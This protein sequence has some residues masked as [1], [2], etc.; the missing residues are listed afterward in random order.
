MIGAV[1]VRNLGE[2]V[3]HLSL[4]GMRD[5]DDALELVLGLG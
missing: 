4:T 2:R 5:A 1:D 3:D